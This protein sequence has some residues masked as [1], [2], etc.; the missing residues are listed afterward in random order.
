MDG[1][2][3]KSCPFCGCTMQPEVMCFQHPYSESYIEWLRK[4]KMLPPISTGYNEGWIVRCY[5]CG[6]EGREGATKDEA[7][8][9][10]N[11]RASQL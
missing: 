7:A 10:W 2:T 3:L 8:R 4:G 5:R 9:N 11:R 6:S 1:K